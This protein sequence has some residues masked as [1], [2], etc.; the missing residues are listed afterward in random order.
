MKKIRGGSLSLPLFLFD[1]SFRSRRGRR[2]KRGEASNSEKTDGRFS[3]E[4]P[5]EIGGGSGGYGFPQNKRHLIFAL[6]C[7]DGG[8][9]RVFLGVQVMLLYAIRII[10]REIQKSK[11]LTKNSKEKKKKEKKDQLKEHKSVL[12]PFITYLQLSFI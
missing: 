9:R 11:L 6:S 7:G 10:R 8:R 12:N 5:A 4:S 1:L 2:R 3:E